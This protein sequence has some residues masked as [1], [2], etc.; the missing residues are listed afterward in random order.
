LRK[1]GHPALR[2][3]IFGNLQFRYVIQLPSYNSG[4]TTRGISV[5]EASS[6]WHEG[7]I[8]A[9]EPTSMVT[10]GEN[11]GEKVIGANECLCITLEGYLGIFVQLGDVDFFARVEEWVERIAAFSREIPIDESVN[12][13]EL[14]NGCIDLLIENAAISNQNNRVEDLLFITTRGVSEGTLRCGA[15]V[16]RSRFG[17]RR[18][19]S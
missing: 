15:L 2:A 18:L 11:R 16:P 7:G 1:F 12:L 9:Q 8:H 14:A 17:L 4:E 10:V 5:S 3:E 6:K 13:H 19:M